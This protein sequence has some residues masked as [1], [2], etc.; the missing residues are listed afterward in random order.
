MSHL[1]SGQVAGTSNYMVSPQLTIEPVEMRSFFNWPQFIIWLDQV[2]ALF[3][4]E[5][6]GISTHASNSQR[7]MVWEW[8]LESQTQ[9]T[10]WITTWG[11]NWCCYCYYTL[12]QRHS[13]SELHFSLIYLLQIKSALRHQP[14]KERVSFACTSLRW[15]RVSYTFF[16][17]YLQLKLQMKNILHSVTVTS[18][19]LGLQ[20]E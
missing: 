10:F 6:W 3:F 20:E 12:Y 16:N 15:W 11:V 1:V 8:D 4:L 5:V 18:P 7:P 19:T 9:S 14:V 2:W 13:Y 17:A